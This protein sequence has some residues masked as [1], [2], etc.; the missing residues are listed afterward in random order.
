MRETLAKNPSGGE[1]SHGRVRFPDMSIWKALG[2][3]RSAAWIEFS[4][5]GTS[6]LLG[7]TGSM[8]GLALGSRISGLDGKSGEE[9]RF[10]TC[11]LTVTLGHEYF[12]RVREDTILGR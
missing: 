2:G 7:L 12:L 9:E 5:L 4:A 3:V 1:A 8:G 6:L 11:S 10:I